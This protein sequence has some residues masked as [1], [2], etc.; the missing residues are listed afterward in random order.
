MEIK[1]RAALCSDNVMYREGGRLVPFAEYQGRG[2]FAV[3]AGSTNGPIRSDHRP[4]N[5]CSLAASL[6]GVMNRMAVVAIAV[7]VL[8]AGAAVAV[9]VLRGRTVEGQ[10]IDSWPSSD[11]ATDLERRPKC[12]V[13]VKSSEPGKCQRIHKGVCYMANWAA[14]AEYY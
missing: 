12:W 6:G 8:L 5:R 3:K 10:A 13:E 1:Q 14:C 11:F 4:P 2:Y 9:V 7:A